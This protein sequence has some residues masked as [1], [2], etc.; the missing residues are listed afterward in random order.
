MLRPLAHNFL[1]GSPGWYKLAVAA[2]LVGNPLV[3]LVLGPFVTG[4]ALIA[5]FVFCLAMA[6]RCYPLQPTGLLAL[7]GVLLGLT[8][9][10][11]VYQEVAANFPVLLLLM[12]MV[13]GIYFMQELLLFVFT[14]IVLGVHSKILLALLFCAIGAFLSA[15]LD[16]LTVAAVIIAV[17]HGF[18]LVFHR[19][20]SGREQDSD[21][22]DSSED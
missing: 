14:K 6:L 20:A 8:S 2:F 22:Y 11:K 4:W 13:A 16:A 12:F 1:G 3:L 21:D 7:E 10:D 17:A 18:Y 5:E 9:P 15:F 19:Y